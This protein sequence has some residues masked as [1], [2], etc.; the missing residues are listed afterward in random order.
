MAAHTL[1]DADLALIEA[2]RLSARRTGRELAKD[3]GL[4]EANV[5][6]RLKRLTEDGLVHFRAFVP[7]SAMGRYV[8]AAVLV[9][10]LTGAALR[11]AG[12]SLANVA[13]C[14]SVIEVD[15]RYLLSHAHAPTMVDL[16]AELEKGLDSGQPYRMQMHHVL[17]CYM[18]P[19]ARARFSAQRPA[20]R[21]TLDDIDLQI[22]AILEAE[23][24]ATFASMSTSVGISPTAVAERYRKLEE[25]G[26]VYPFVLI[27]EEAEARPG[28]LVRVEI[29]GPLQPP[30]K[31]IEDIIRPDCSAMM[32]GPAQFMA[33][34][35]SADTRPTNE[36]VTQIMR[37]PGVVHASIAPI[38]HVFKRKG[39]MEASG[40]AAAC[41]N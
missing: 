11:A 13:A 18:F 35:N 39:V 23:G 32:G 28:R 41:T 36:L 8:E 37:V 4:S 22:L 20:D 27:A 40:N 9:E 31:A 2:L 3:T 10:G 12:N 33:S 1:D 14:S 6:R 7:P 17:R 34:L 38:T 30:A 19:N 29:A 25:S 5:S 16:N 26:V 21:A 15:H 24:R